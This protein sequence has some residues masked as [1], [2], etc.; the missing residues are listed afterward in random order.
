MGQIIRCLDCYEWVG[1]ESA[2]LHHAQ[3]VIEWQE[4]QALKASKEAKPVLD[5]VFKGKVTVGDRAGTLDRGVGQKYTLSQWE[6]SH[7][8]CIG[9]YSKRDEIQHFEW[10]KCQAPY[11]EPD[12]QVLSA[13]ILKGKA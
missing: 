10:E 9:V 6:G 8:K 1:V 5:S 3:H 13:P 11:I 4:R 7:S 12:D 2:D